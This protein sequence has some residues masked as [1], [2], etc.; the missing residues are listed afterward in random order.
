M[1]PPRPGGRLPVAIVLTGLALLAPA[2]RLAA[3]TA[4]DPVVIDHAEELRRVVEG[5]SLTYF[6][7]GNVRAHRGNVRMRSQLAT[8]Y[9]QS[10][11][12]DFQRN[13]HFWDRTTEIYADRVV[14]E[15]IPDVALA[16][17][18]VQLIDRETKSEVAAESLRYFREDGRI[19]AW[20]RPH[21]V[22]VPRD[23][24]A[25]E[26]F[27]LY[28][29]VMRF[30]SDSVRSEMVAVDSVLIE[31]TDLTAVADSLLY[32]DETGIVR[33]RLSPRVETEETFLVA[34][35]IDVLMEENEITALVA[36][37]R[38]RAVNKRDSVPGSVRMAFDNVSAN[39][40][41]EG[42]SLYISFA[43]GGIDW[44]VAERNA[45]SLNY[46]RESV[47]GPVETWSI[48]YLQGA[49]LRLNFRGDSLSQVVATGGHR[50]LFRSEEVRI[51][52]PE[53]RPSVPIPLP[54]PAAVA[55]PG[56][57]SPASASPRRPRGS[58][59]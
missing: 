41:L 23:T 15:E 35:E 7:T 42:D 44:L 33:L 39:S 28:A 24:T 26:P 34:D 6:L 29:D 17:G 45:R 5:D 59:R 52:G 55:T 57:T 20:P 49:R 32:D 13:V 14:Y 3:Q 51:G 9:R 10:S 8:I 36:E 4:Q 22:L 58:T 46:T 25:G 1:T 47:P 30:R 53:R 54:E 18:D 40:F 11:I 56:T 27:D 31:R 43:E 2:G 19:I 37:S 12:A 16:T 21:A 38:A 50:G 48:N